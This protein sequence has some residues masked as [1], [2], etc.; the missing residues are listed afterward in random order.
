MSKR[1]QTH[2][3]THYVCFS[4]SMILFYIIDLTTFS[5]LRPF[6]RDSIVIFFRA[7]PIRLQRKHTYVLLS[8]SF[9]RGHRIRGISIL[10]NMYIYCADNIH[11]IISY[12]L[13]LKM[14]QPSL[15]FQNISIKLYE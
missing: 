15:N 10:R 13:L 7:Y 14:F 8:F 1:Y 4:Q 2:I 3:H 6:C 9:S 11:K 5:F 12:Q